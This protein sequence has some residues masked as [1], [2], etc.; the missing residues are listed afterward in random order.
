[1]LNIDITGVAPENNFT[2]PKEYLFTKNQFGVACIIPDMAPFYTLTRVSIKVSAGA[3]FRDRTPL[4]VDWWCDLTQ[5]EMAELT[6]PVLPYISAFT[7]TDLGVYGGVFG[8]GDLIDVP[9]MLSYQCLGTDH[10]NDPSIY[11]PILAQTGVE[12]EEL[13]WEIFLRMTNTFPDIIGVDIPIDNLDISGVISALTDIGKKITEV[14]AS[15]GLASERTHLTNF[16]NPHK[17][18]KSTIGLS[19]VAN[20]PPANATKYLGVTDNF[21]Y[22]STEMLKKQILANLPIPTDVTPGYTKFNRLLTDV[23][24][25]NITDAITLQDAILAID[26]PWEQY[27]P[28][29]VHD[30]KILNWTNVFPVWGF[31]VYALTLGDLIWAAGVW[32]DVTP[33]PFRTDTGILE[34]PTGLTKVRM[35][36]FVKMLKDCHIPTTEDTTDMPI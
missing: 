12:L 30:I 8:T 22:I 24:A 13:S 15:N 14:G 20:L 33:I 7:E 1:M 9:V 28:I 27:M 19:K 2:D 4:T 34:I 36:D 29:G 25:L 5:D 23:D 32:F 35:L 21:S 16:S 3:V 26:G 11:P 10:V 6:T 18:N 17:V 31:N